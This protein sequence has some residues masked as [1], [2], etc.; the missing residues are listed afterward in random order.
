M[1]SKLVLLL[2]ISTCLTSGL[3]A[4]DLQRGKLKITLHEKTG[5][6]ALAGAEDQLKPVWTPLFSPEDVTTSKWKLQIGDKTAVLG[7]D[8]G[9]TA[10]TEATPTGAKVVWTSKALVVTAT[11]DFLLSAAASVA[12]GVKLGLSVVNVSD[13]PTKVGLRWLVDTSLGEKKDHFRLSG[14]EVVNAETRL[15]GT[16]PDWWLSSPGVDEPMGLLVMTGKGATPPSRVVF[17]NWKRLDDA[18]WDLTYKQGRDFNQLPYSF[19][20]SA[21]SQV[22]DAQE[23]PSGGTREVTV[24]LGLKSARTLEGS[25]VGSANPLDDL[26]KKNQNPALGALDQ[27][28]VSLQTLLA[29]IDAKLADPGRVTSEDLKLLQAVL[30]QIETR[31]KALEATKP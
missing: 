20:D 7:E 4:L 24:L 17:A 6:F 31:R 25:R 26:L 12:D 9:F 29:Q 2:M 13:A 3:A 28:L 22:Y 19:N 23:I 5:R 1:Q 8:S 21:V 16:M 30:D 15:E 11:Y 27:D 14:G 18:T 10:V